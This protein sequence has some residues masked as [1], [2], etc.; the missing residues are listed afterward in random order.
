MSFAGSPPDIDLNSLK[1]VLTPRTSRKELLRLDKQKLVDISVK[2]DRGHKFLGLALVILGFFLFYCGFY[3]SSTGRV[4]AAA[5]FSGLAVI[6]FLS[7]F[8][9]IYND[10]LSGK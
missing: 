3:E 9:N 8:S 5:V 4:G 7:S 10:Q 2:D 1:G 6:S